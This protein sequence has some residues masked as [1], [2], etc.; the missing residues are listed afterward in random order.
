M[1]FLEAEVDVKAMVK[2]WFIFIQ[3]RNRFMFKGPFF[4]F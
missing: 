4:N 3:L 2:A 1:L